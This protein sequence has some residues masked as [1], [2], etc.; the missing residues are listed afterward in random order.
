MEYTRAGREPQPGAVL[1]VSFIVMDD[2]TRNEPIKVILC[3]TIK[4]PRGEEVLDCQSLKRTCVENHEHLTLYSWTPLPTNLLLCQSVRFCRCSRGCH[5]WNL[6]DLLRCAF[7][8]ERAW[9]SLIFGF[10][11]IPFIHGHTK[12]RASFQSMIVE[13]PRVLPVHA[14]CNTNLESYHQILQSIFSHS[15]AFC[16]SVLQRQLVV[17]CFGTSTHAF[18]HKSQ[19]GTIRFDKALSLATGHF[20]RR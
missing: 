15:R 4:Y 10:M 13:L 18:F 1:N 17:Y 12:S 9:R 19:N 7:R 5:H 20:A 14:P 16:K 3:D 6:F 2:S 8:S 11:S